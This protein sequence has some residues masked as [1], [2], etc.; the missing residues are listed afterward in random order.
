MKTESI[1][2][3]AHCGE[4]DTDV[5]FL[6]VPGGILITA[7]W[8]HPECREKLTQTIAAQRKRM[9]AVKPRQKRPSSY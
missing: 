5:M 4:A 3:C 2:V 7:G 8:L 1:K 6:S 9:T